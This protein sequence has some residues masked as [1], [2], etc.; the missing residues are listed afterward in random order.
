MAAQRQHK[1]AATCTCLVGD[2][3]VLTILQ[4]VL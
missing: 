4:D 3:N 2:L 1:T